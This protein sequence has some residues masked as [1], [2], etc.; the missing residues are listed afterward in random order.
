MVNINKAIVVLKSALSLV[1]EAV[2]Q[3]DKVLFVGSSELSPEAV[4]E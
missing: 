1:F 2:A 3:V 4:G